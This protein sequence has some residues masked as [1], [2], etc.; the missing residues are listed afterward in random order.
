MKLSPTFTFITAIA[1]SLLA[2]T[3]STGAVE[4]KKAPI[5]TIFPQG[6]PNPYGKFFTG[7][8][9]LSR[10]SAKDDVFNAPLANVTFEP[11]PTGIN[12]AEARYFLFYPEK[13]AIRKKAEN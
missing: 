7:Q 6:E 9:Y 5:D 4:M 13:D 3:N 8:T 2:L 10:L 12:T 11:E 1:V